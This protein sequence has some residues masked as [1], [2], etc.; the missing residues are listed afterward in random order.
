MAEKLHFVAF[1]ILS[2]F[3]LSCFI[4]DNSFPVSIWIPC[5]IHLR[6][7]YSGYKLENFDGLHQH[8]GPF[9][10]AI[11]AA[12]STAILSAILNRPCKLLAIPRRFES[13]FVYTGD[14]NLR[15]IALEIAA[16]NRR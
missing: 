8:N 15:E 10:L 5:L 4:M 9:T 12:N 13:P 3:L 14:L 11:S 7:S 2:N 6:S 16:K 1:I